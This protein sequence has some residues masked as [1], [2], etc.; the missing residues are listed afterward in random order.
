MALFEE[1][2]ANLTSDAYRPRRWQ[3]ELAAQEECVNRL[4]RIP[5]GFGKTLGVLVAW[6]WNRVRRQDD[7]WP[8][9]LVWCL[10]MRVL[11]EQTRDEVQGCLSAL[12]LLWKEGS[13]HASKV[14]VH[15]LMG[16]VDCG[17][18]HLYPEH[19]AVLIGT[20]DMLLSRTLNR[21]Y[22][23]PRARWPMEFGLLHQ[24]CLWVMDEVQLMD[25][26][27]ATSG[28]LQAFRDDDRLAARGMRP[29][30]TWW[31]SATLQRDWIT[32]SP[33]TA[34]MAPALPQSDIP[35]DQR[36]GDLWDGVAK[37]HRRAQIN[38]PKAIARLVAEEHNKNG[39]GAGGPTLVILN[40]VERALHV[41]QA[42]ARDKSITAT[43]VRLV[44]SRF[45]PYE[46]AS[47]RVAFLNRA[48]C[49]AGTDRIVIATQVVEAGVDISAGLLI[50]ELAPWPSLVQRFGRCARWGGKAEVIVAD[51]EPKDDKAAAPY[52][53]DELD[54]AR[55]ALDQLPDAAPL[56]LE[57]FEES[58]SELLARLY[59]Y[60]PRHLLLRHEL[61]ELF[62]TTPDLSGADIDISRF[63]R[64]GEERDLSVFWTEVSAKENP[65]PD[66]RPSRDALCTVPFLKAREWLCKAKSELL[67]DGLRAWVWDWLDDA[68]RGAKRRD[69][70]P[71]QTVLV[72]ADC[73]GYD[74]K[75]G[76]LPESN[77][78]VPPV[79]MSSIDVGERGDAGQDDES[80]S[81]YDWQT[82]AVHGRE[83]G[84]VAQAIAASL[85][86]E[87]ATLFDLAG[88]WH[89]AGKVF[90]AFQGSIVAGDRPP[91]QDLA[92]AP[93]RA[94]LH[95]SKLYPMDG[96]RRAGFR[97]ELASTL[98][99]FAVLQRHAPDHP[100]LLGRWRDLLTEAGMP[101]EPPW[102]SDR[103]PNPLEREIL[104]LDVDGFNLLAYLVCTHH[105]KVRVAWHACPADQESGDARPRIRGIVDGDQL[106]AVALADGTGAFYDLPASLLDLATAAA[107]LNRRTGTGWTERVLGLLSR[108]GPFS[109]A[110]LEALLR[111]ADQ[112]ASRRPVADPLLENHNNQHG[113][114]TSDRTLAQS[115]GD[116]EARDPLAADPGERGGE[117]GLR[118]G[119]GELGDVGSRTRPPPHATRYLETKLGVLSYAE[120]AP[121]LA[122]K[123]QALEERI[124]AGQF[125]DHPLDD[126]LIEL[127][128]RHI[129]GVLT[130]KLAG[131]RRHNVTVGDHA[132]P[133]FFLIPVLVRDYTRDL[134]ARIDALTEL[135][136]ERLLEALAFAEGRFL[137]IHPFADFNGR[138]TRVYL[139]E[140][141]RRL[142]LPAIDLVPSP[143][144]LEGYLAALRA[145]DRNDWR[146][147]IAIW[148][149]RFEQ[150]A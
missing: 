41:F 1:Y 11:V 105:G 145:A 85:A 135:P 117:H 52:T 36:M 4:I 12:G 128:H 55:E 8:R 90:P 59:P 136:D 66:R 139:R 38:D 22:G 125:A 14:G 150:V 26:G 71:G 37:P 56:Y 7:C 70:Y 80:L 84:V 94:W 95:V 51:L 45:R 5:T 58:H 15:L 44:H 13:D 43:D 18:W 2:F 33:D 130:P 35:A 103:P 75:L 49:A 138:V 104:A 60:Q 120:L 76:W 86:P 63:I 92:K 102:L 50:T 93:R 101:P 29:C 137:S 54:A 79:P 87:L 134:A 91:R 142:D 109:L 46:R 114:E 48:A 64:S 149:A 148:R 23:A 31:M 40:T 16:G 73:G 83:T 77:L 106:P 113:L 24:D 82:I 111:A 110:W 118:A 47:W 100:A 143:E 42:L 126:A 141:L 115:A 131:W 116:G 53:R 146:P 10:P 107:G 112:R 27:L 65:T 61:D 123:V 98:A 72:A 124:A 17:D 81:A 133:D 129:C 20:Q 68:W 119:I 32:K 108:H 74:P 97:H 67:K 127:F 147:L 30:Y 3:S 122:R 34:S 96:R 132:P 62:D 99:L 19:C 88:R 6:L 140:I 39:R 69:L 9:R 21:G 28:Q 78:P 121:H 89:D 144:G 57:A 25:V